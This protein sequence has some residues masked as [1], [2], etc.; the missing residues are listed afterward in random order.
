[1]LNKRAMRIIIHTMELLKDM[2]NWSHDKALYTMGLNAKER[3][4]V[5]KYY[6]SSNIARNYRRTLPRNKRS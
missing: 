5:I 6:E 2:H 4:K 3:K 1:M